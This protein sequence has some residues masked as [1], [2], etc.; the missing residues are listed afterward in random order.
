MKL[1]VR[2]SFTLLAV[3]CLAIGISSQ[4]FAQVVEVE[5]NDP[6]VEAQDIGPIDVTGTFSVQGSLDTPPD[7]P[8]VDFFRF[9]A[10]PGAQLIADH[11][12]EATGKGTLPD[13]LLGLFDSDC[14]LLTDDDDS[15]VGLN[16]RLRFD[17]PPDGVFVLAATSFADF[18][19]TGAGGSSGTYELTISPPPP[20]IGSIAGRIVDAL[21]GE[22]LPGNESPF[23]FAQLFRC[24]GDDCFEF[25]D[26]QGADGEGRFRF[27][28]D[29][30]D[31]P[32]PVGTYQLRAF[33]DEFEQVETD[34]I[35]V[36]EGEDL[37]VGDILLQ[38]PPIAISDIQPCDDLSPQGDT[39]QY[40][41]RVTNNT[42]A[43]LTGIAWSPVDGFGLP[44][45]LTFTLFEASTRGGSR[46][47]V[48]ERLAVRP[49]GQQTLQFRF[50]VPP[51]VL[52]AT[53]CTRV[54]VGLDPSPLV[55]PVKESFLFCITGGTTDFELMSES[56]S[57]KIFESLGGNSR[58]L[59]D[60]VPTGNDNSQ[61]PGSKG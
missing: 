11:E 53:F 23:A 27:D 43:R 19:F 59:Q 50:D 4:S 12:G 51:S 40:S 38:P 56:E 5:P 41:V 35:E 29:S 60:M 47:A 55:T 32:L 1:L 44:S 20:S 54:F 37:D 28:R 31:Q 18:G 36:G 2:S 61:V 33:A 3:F 39:C 45:S 26:S 6:C 14:N 13:P 17:V 42:N 24:D 21:T 58:S 30:N 25:V 34:P 16:S 46:L 22:P 48:R 8:D 49:F 7:E 57:Q 15:G 52:G 10:T 9:S